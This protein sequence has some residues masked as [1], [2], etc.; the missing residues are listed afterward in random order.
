MANKYLQQFFYSRTK[1]LCAIHG[2]ILIAADASVTSTTIIGATVTKT[3]T[4]EYTIVLDSSYQALMSLQASLSAAVA[5]DLVAQ[6][7]AADVVTARTIV[8]RLNTGATPT[9]P[10]AVCR[11][12]VAILLR[13]SS[14]VI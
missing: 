8:V 14:V 10:S 9:N 1:K 7:G 4:G 2:Q 13:D 5:V 12:N 11:I 3:G 6:F